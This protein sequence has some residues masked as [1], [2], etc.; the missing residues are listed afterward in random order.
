MFKALMQEF[1]DGKTEAKV[2]ILKIL[3]KLRSA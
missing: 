2:S 1:A 3:V